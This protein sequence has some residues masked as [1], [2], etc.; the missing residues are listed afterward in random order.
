VL[1]CFCFGAA[2]AVWFYLFDAQKY[3]VIG[4]IVLTDD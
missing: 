3:R 2:I 4:R 1:A